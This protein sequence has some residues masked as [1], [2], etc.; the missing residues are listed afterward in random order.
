VFFVR[1]LYTCWEGNRSSNIVTTISYFEIHARAH[2]L[3][4][5][6]ITPKNHI[7]NT[8]R[9]NITDFKIAKWQFHHFLYHLSHDLSPTVNNNNN[10]NNNNTLA[11]ANLSL[12]SNCY[13]PLFNT[14][15]ILFSFKLCLLLP[16]A[17]SLLIITSC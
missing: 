9:Y 8:R 1:C 10:N 3:T 2:T 7:N 11:T 17:K 5:T 16:P 6:H 14:R 15:Q 12:I 4:H 13:R